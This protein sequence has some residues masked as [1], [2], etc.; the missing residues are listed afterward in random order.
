[1]DKH[2][3]LKFIRSIG[4]INKNIVLVV[5]LSAL[6]LATLPFVTQENPAYGLLALEFLAILF[7]TPLIYG[8]FYEGVRCDTTSGW[9]GLFKQHWWNYTLV[10]FILALP[11]SALFIFGIHK[12]AAA[13]AILA[14]IIEVVTLYVMPLVFITRQRIPAIVSGITC[15]FDNLQYSIPLIVIA[16]AMSC[17]SALMHAYILEP[18][19]GSA[20]ISANFLWSLIMYYIDVAV[21]ATATI[22]V[23]EDKRFQY[24]VPVS[25]REDA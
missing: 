13:N 5:I 14:A 22:I 21:F 10:S 12:M 3:Q 17:I 7:I 4:I 18:L 15:L 19:Q 8:R 24:L 9:R 2:I 23:L 1:M 25:N 6:P 20:L 16:L 11:Y